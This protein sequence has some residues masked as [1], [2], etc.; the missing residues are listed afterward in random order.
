M[1]KEAMEDYKRYRQDVEVNNRAVEVGGSGRNPSRATCP[2]RQGAA[3][4]WAWAL[5]RWIS[6]EV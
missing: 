4:A 1:M 2:F 6:R 5:L 3:A